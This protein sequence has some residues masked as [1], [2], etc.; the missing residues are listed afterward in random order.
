MADINVGTMTLAQMI[1]RIIE[2]QD[3]FE[4]GAWILSMIDTLTAERDAAR[5]EAERLRPA[6]AAWEALEAHTQTVNRGENDQSARRRLMLAI[7][8]AR[9]AAKV[10]KP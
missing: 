7:D 5:S 9:E 4:G 10:E 3:T 8:A 2:K 6:S 1:A